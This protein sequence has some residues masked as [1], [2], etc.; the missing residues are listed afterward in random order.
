MII[1][2]NNNNYKEYSNTIQ[3][4]LDNGTEYVFVV[5]EKI[6]GYAIVNINTKTIISVHLTEIPYAIELINYLITHFNQRPKITIA[7]KQKPLYIEV[8]KHFPMQFV[9][10]YSDKNICQ[11]N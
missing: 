10:T 6:Y 5:D 8:F 9:L 4:I 2:S 7:R 3:T 11:Y 1:T